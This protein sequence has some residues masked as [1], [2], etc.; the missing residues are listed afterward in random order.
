VVVL[1]A[2]RSGGGKSQ[3]STL[4]EAAGGYYMYVIQL[5]LLCIQTTGL[6]ESAMARGRQ[7]ARSCARATG[8]PKNEA[9]QACSS[10]ILVEQVEC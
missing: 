10:E 4:S 8:P 2:L 6:D 9:R 1:A 5:A 3:C 7:R